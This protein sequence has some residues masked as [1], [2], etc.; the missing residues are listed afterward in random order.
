[1]TLLY[2]ESE[3]TFDKIEKTWKAIDH[4]G[5]NV[6][7]LDY[8]EPSIQIISFE[9]MLDNYSSVA[10]PNMYSHWSFG[11]SFIANYEAFKKGRMPLAYEVVINTNPCLAYL[12]ENNTMTMQTLVLAHA[13]CG[14]GSFFKNNYLFKKWTDADFILDYLEFARQYIKTCEIKYG[15]LPVESILDAAHALSNYGV[16]KYKRRGSIN[17][18][19]K[20]VRTK[21]LQDYLDS[22]SNELLDKTTKVDV[23][24]RTDKIDNMIK[25]INEEE[26]KLPE[27]NIL[28]YI[29]K[30]SHV[31]APYMKE[32]VRIVRKIHQYFYPQMQTQLMN[33]GWACFIHYHILQELYNTKQISEG[34]YTEFL[35][36]HTNVCYQPDYANINV[37]ALG[38]AMMMDIKR[39]CQEP[40]DEDKKLF[41]E[42]AGKD[43]LPTMK[44]I[45]ENYRDDSFVLQFLSPKV[46]RKFN[47]FALRDDKSVY[48]HKVLATHADDEYTDLKK[49]LSEYFARDYA[50]PDIEIVNQYN[51][52]GAQE[53]I[54][55]YK[56][57][58]NKWLDSDKAHKVLQYLD[59]L[60][61]SPVTLHI[62]ED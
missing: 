58:S 25:N 27:E 47:L 22:I 28:Y 32:I 42:I 51:N 6:F 33:E 50:V 39:I 14:H 60:W 16:D 26:R 45:I 55:Q 29:E 24:T 36:S 20:R 15:Q 44:D 30:N 13:V 41:P 18:E 12:M 61:G 3:W 2:N 59:Y 10:M 1:M 48:F 54:L 38:F 62:K 46:I 35:I 52:D 5:K 43:W 21:E 4:I 31:L 37:Y 40:D 11:K 57:N 9:Q 34:H 49:T 17:K 7:E 23:Q 19:L 56:D 8:Y 53:L